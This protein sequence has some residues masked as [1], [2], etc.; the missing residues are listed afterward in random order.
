M[1][2]QWFDD[3]FVAVGQ[4][5]N[6]IASSPDGIN[7]TGFGVDKISFRGRVLATDGLH[8]FAGGSQST[9]LQDG[10]NFARSEGDGFISKPVPQMDE[11]Q[12]IVWFASAGALVVGGIGDTQVA[13]STNSGDDWVGGPIFDTLYNITVSDTQVEAFGLVTIDGDSV[14]AST[15]S[16]DGLTWSTPEVVNQ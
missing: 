9:F 10:K 15:Y 12:R 1:K 6:T 14:Y 3:R 11:V 8:I 7:W 16:S 5:S 2:I 4:G 13:S